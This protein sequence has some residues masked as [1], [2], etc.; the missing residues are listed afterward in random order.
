MFF[1]KGNKRSVYN[2]I[3]FQKRTTPTLYEKKEKLISV[4]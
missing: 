3:T 2:K 1:I 4:L